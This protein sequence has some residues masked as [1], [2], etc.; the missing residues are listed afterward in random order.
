IQVIVPLNDPPNPALGEPRNE[1]EDRKGGFPHSEISGSKGASASP[2]LIAACHVLLR[3]SAPRHPSEAL[4][5]LIVSQQNPRTILCRRMERGVQ[6]AIAHGFT[7]QTM[8]S[9]THP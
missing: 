3:L 6:P 1:L 5:R 9:R 4:Q 2:E 8:S 7:C